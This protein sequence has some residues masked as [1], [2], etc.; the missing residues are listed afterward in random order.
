MSLVNCPSCGGLLPS[1][2]HCCPHCHCRTPLWRR[3]V[4]AIGAV[5]GIG[6]PA[7]GPLGPQPVVEYGPAII[8][9]GGNP[10]DAGDGG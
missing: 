2:R 10:P 8:L 3:W 7:C 4:W 1:N 6:A 5:I 9:D